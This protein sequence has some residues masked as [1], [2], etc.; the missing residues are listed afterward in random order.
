MHF[1]FNRL[2]YTHQKIII[3]IEEHAHAKFKRSLV[4][5]SSSPQRTHANA[6]YNKKQIA[7]GELCQSV[8]RARAIIIEDAAQCTH[9]EYN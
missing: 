3:I 1:Q 5:P 6:L 4:P 9:L 7:N 2:C 8:S